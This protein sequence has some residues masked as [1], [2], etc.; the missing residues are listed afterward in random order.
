MERREGTLLSLPA[1]FS[2]AAYMIKICKY[3]T[4]HPITRGDAHLDDF[5][6]LCALPCSRPTQHKHHQWLGG[7]HRSPHQLHS[8]RL[9]RNAEKGHRSKD[10]SY[11]VNI[12]GG[13]RS[14]PSRQRRARISWE[15]VTVGQRPKG[16]DR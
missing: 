15:A 7:R 2:L 14:G 13:S 1:T 12:N 11:Y 5:G 8:H 6:T 3:S 10:W 16:G 9:Q 4:L